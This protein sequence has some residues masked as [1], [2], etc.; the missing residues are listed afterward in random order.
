MEIIYHRM[1][2][3]PTP[4]DHGWDGEGDISWTDEMFPEDIEQYVTGN[5]EDE[6]EFEDDL[7]GD[8]FDDDEDEDDDDDEDEDDYE[9]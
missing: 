1:L 6:E 2:D 7:E 4:A 9:D 5:E 8:I 3:L